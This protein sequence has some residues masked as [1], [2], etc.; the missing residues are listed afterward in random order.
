M[1]SLQQ[2]DARKMLSK[3]KMSDTHRKKKHIEQLNLLMVSLTF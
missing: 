3:N 2:V 1:T